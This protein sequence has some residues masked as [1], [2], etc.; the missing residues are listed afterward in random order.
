ME[1][2]SR[3]FAAEPGRRAVRH[4]PRAWRSAQRVA[5]SARNDLDPDEHAGPAAE[6]VF[7]S[8]P[9]EGRAAPPMPVL[10]GDDEAMAGEPGAEENRRPGRAAPARREHHEG[11]RSVRRRRRRQVRAPCERNARLEEDRSAL[12]HL[13]QRT[14]GAHRGWPSGSRT[15]RAGMRG[16]ARRQL[17]PDFPAEGGAAVSGG[18]DEGRRG[19]RG[20]PG[21]RVRERRRSPPGG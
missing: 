5:A 13:S 19:P 1:A 9:C 18:A 11:E 7:R 17:G 14:R 20:V 8:R 12:E 2:M 21:C 6:D 16:L 10:D 3:G 15:A 4:H